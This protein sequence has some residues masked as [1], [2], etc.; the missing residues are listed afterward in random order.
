M[1]RACL[2]VLAG[3]F[4]AQHSRVGLSLDL[5]KLLFVA[6]AVLYLYGRLRSGAWL[7]L[8]FALFMHAGQSIIDARLDPRFAGDSILTQVRIVDFPKS[9]GA[10]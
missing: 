6:A 10:F 9:N 2:L 5:C 4:A 8:G 1:I 3:G 7:I